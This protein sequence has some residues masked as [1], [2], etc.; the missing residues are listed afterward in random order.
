MEEVTPG[1]AQWSI[2]HVL[3]QGIRTTVCRGE[4]KDSFSL[5]G[6]RTPSLR[7]MGRGGEK[8]LNGIFLEKGC[9]REPS[10]N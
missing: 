9:S 3:A 10:I 8:Y 4:T 5:V 7:K 2:L 6:L 1:E